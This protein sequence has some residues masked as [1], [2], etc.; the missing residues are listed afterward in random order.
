[1]NTPTLSNSPV[2]APPTLELRLAVRTRPDELAPVMFHTWRKLLFLHWRVEPELI[3]PLLP[4]GLTVDTFD[5]SAWVGV[6][7]F[8]MREIRPSWSPSVPWISNFLELNLRTYAYDEQGIP[9]VWFLSLNANRVLAVTLG[10]RWF[11][12]P[13]FTCRM[14]TSTD[15][16]GLIDYRCRR[17]VDPEQR[18]CHYRYRPTGRPE[19]ATPGTLEFFLV[20]RYILFAMPPSG[21]LMRG[22]VWHTPYEIQAVDVER[23]DDQLFALDGLP[24]PNRPADHAAFSP[25]VTVDVY[26][27]ADSLPWVL[28][29]S[30]R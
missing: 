2:S 12:L 20:E 5:G 7:P 9:G 8:E 26:P 13:Y 29:N 21:R 15:A 27:L 19:S 4:A 6:V 17:L 11:R 30:D 23:E 14:S 24:R 25:G 18:T 1:M 16:T 3:R 28:T 22:Q 10:R